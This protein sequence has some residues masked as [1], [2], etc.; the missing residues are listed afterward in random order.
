MPVSRLGYSD[1]EIENHFQSF[2]VA[3][4]SYVN[5]VLVLIMLICGVNYIFI[6]T[7]E[8]LQKRDKFGVN[9]SDIVFFRSKC[10]SHL[11]RLMIFLPKLVKVL[12]FFF[13]F[14]LLF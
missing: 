9:W 6:L 12:L 4:S 5:T 3:Y 10:S 2:L 1:H 11:G 13:F 14:W 7:E 8:P